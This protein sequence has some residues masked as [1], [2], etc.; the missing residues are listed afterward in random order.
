[1]HIR[2]EWPNT[3]IVGAWSGERKSLGMGSMSHLLFMKHSI[4][5][6]WE[7]GERKGR[8]ERREKVKESEEEGKKAKNLSNRTMYMRNRSS[9]PAKS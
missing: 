6:F 4:H 1:M 5:T 3:F 2:S 9:N 8:R 7:G